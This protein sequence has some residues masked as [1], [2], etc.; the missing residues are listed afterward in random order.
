MTLQ[1]GIEHLHRELVTL[2]G[3]VEP[4]VTRGVAALSHPDG[5]LLERMRRDDEVIDRREVQIEEECLELLALHQPVAED[6]RR[7]FACTK[8]TGELERIADLAVNISERAHTL[9]G[10]PHVRIPEGMSRMASMGLAMLKDA[11]NAY[12]DCDEEAAR[13]VCRRDDAVDTLNH[14]MIDSL[15][16]ELHRNP[17]TMDSILELMWASLHLER[18]AD[19]TT[20]IAE[21]VVYM[22]TGRIVRHDRSDGEHAA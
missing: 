10:K 19:H 7:I 13:D 11:I 9:V 12:L 1:G 2:V 22:V 20:N 5:S 15:K 4:M 6:L 17:V 14:S 8:I 18:I 16:A 3:L 21:D